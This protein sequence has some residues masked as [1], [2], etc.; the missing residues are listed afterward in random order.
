M[1]YPIFFCS[2]PLGRITRS[3]KRDL[4]KTHITCSLKPR[5]SNAPMTEIFGVLASD[6]AATIKT[7]TSQIATTSESKKPRRST[8]N[9]VETAAVEPVK[10]V[11]EPNVVKGQQ[12]VESPAVVS[13]NEAIVSP[14]AKATTPELKKPRRSARNLV[15]SIAVEQ[16]PAVAEPSVE[17]V[18]QPIESP[19]VVSEDEAIVSD[20]ESD[21][22]APKLRK[23]PNL[24]RLRRSFRESL[25]ARRTSEST[26]KELA[27]IKSPAYAKTKG[28]CSKSNEVSASSTP[29][30][31]VDSSSNYLIETPKSKPR[32]SQTVESQTAKS[33][34]VQ[35]ARKFTQANK[36]EG[37]PASP[38]VNETMESPMPA[39]SSAHDKSRIEA[40]ATTESLLSTSLKNLT[41][42]SKT[43]DSRE[44]N[45]GTASPVTPIEVEQSDR[46]PHCSPQSDANYTPELMK[47]FYEHSF[48]INSPSVFSEDPESPQICTQTKEV[49]V[50]SSNSDPKSFVIAPLELPPSYEEVLHGCRKLDIPEHVFQQ[51]FYS[52]PSDVTKMT[53]VGFLVLRI[54]GNKLSD[55]EP[56]Q[57]SV[58]TNNQ[59]LAA[60]RRKQLVSIGGPAMLQRYR[61]EQQ[62]RQYFSSQKSVIMEP[63]ASPPS[64][65]D[66]KMWL[67]AR[68]LLKQRQGGV[69]EDRS[70][71]NDVD[72]PIKIKRQKITMMLNEA[73]GDAV[74]D[75]DAEISRSDLTLTPMS[76]IQTPASKAEYRETPLSSKLGSRRG[77]K[78]QFQAAAAAQEGEA[79]PAS[80]QSSEQSVASSAALEELDRS[81]F[82][83]QLDS[84]SSGR[85]SHDLSFGLSHATLDNTFGFK[86]N[87]ENLQQAKA[88]I[89]VSLGVAFL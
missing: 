13:R 78:L 21:M 58:L 41:A 22:S 59:G 52:N 49:A 25:L 44:N 60:W 18:Q 48:I 64:R 85:N 53:E 83:R 33:K 30:N 68:E 61:N 47:S 28:F 31:L 42:A 65:R 24:R 71:S 14:I 1:I 50:P 5:Q 11:D 63:A 26:S 66:A 73:D 16:V 39:R 69:D 7:T 40:T 88:D 80:N 36:T 81:S 34:V 32:A 84:I 56:F 15:H 55:L 38:N 72:S 17:T 35:S 27:A 76:Q 70:A 57:S 8:R 19:A 67:K 12:P 4:D 77:L 79:A 75:D 62:I 20:T 3:R 74:S 54:P 86:V 37:T 51:P 23:T 9:R 10:P 6:E 89:E 87:L 82:V 29:L 46:T 2:T 45:A 43:S